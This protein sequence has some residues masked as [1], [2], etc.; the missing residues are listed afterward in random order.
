MATIIVGR[1]VKPAGADPNIDSKTSNFKTIK[2]SRAQDEKIRDFQLQEETDEQLKENKIEAV[3]E[4]YLGELKK[5]HVGYSDKTAK[6]L[7]TQLKKIWCNI[8]TLEKGKTT[9]VFRAPWDRTLNIT[10]Y[11][12]HLDKAQLK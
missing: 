3:D 10:T 11:E 5:D 6:Y 8:T 12:R 1:Q 2:L 4:E 7:L 9:G